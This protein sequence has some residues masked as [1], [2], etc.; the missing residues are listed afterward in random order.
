MHQ[1]RIT[2]FE[3]TMLIPCENI[4]EEEEQTKP[5]YTDV[6]VICLGNKPNVLYTPCRHIATCLNCENIKTIY[7]CPM[8]RED[9]LKKKILFKQ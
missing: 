4:D 6:C 8:C 1:Y 9:C 5:Y 3:K 7:K 2:L